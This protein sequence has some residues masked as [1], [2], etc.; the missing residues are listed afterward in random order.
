[1]KIQERLNHSPLTLTLNIAQKISL[2]QS[3]DAPTKT[4]EA[5]VQLANV[6]LKRICPHPL[7]C[8]K[9]SSGV[10]GGNSLNR[11]LRGGGEDDGP[12]ILF[13]GVHRA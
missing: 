9:N 8:G 5:P 13:F 11:F 7:D 6:T 12:A 3:P 4:L 10:P 2:S 1:M